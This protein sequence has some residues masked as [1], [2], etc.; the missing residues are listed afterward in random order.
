MIRLRL[1][2]H[3]RVVFL[4][5]CKHIFLQSDE[6]ILLYSITKSKSTNTAT[7]RKKFKDTDKYRVVGSIFF[8]PYS[9]HITAYTQFTIHHSDNLH[10]YDHLLFL[11]TVLHHQQYCFNVTLLC[12]ITS[13]LTSFFC[14]DAMHDEYLPSVLLI[15]RANRQPRSKAQQRE[16]EDIL[17]ER[18][19]VQWCGVRE[20][21]G[22]TDD[23]H[24]RTIWN[25]SIDT[26]RRAVLT[27]QNVQ[28]V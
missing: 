25:K 4:D 18:A 23:P 6:H 26:S 3:T 20:E 1:L 12:G 22:P 2:Q 24:Q 19:I 13:S 17:V 11:P 9:R 21:P 16:R 10:G 7:G 8:V 5:D 28:T 27:S 15:Y 14:A